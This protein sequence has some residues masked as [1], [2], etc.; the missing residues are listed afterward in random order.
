MAA[1]TENISLLK[2]A[3]AAWAQSKGTDCECWMNI[4]SDEASLASLAAGA[5]EMSFSAPRDSKSQILRYLQELTSDWDMVS[6]DMDDFIADGDRVVAVGQVAWRNKTTGKVAETP[7]VD[8]WR[9][10]QGKVV[11]LREFY[12]TARAFAAATPD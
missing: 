9:F 6:F 2:D 8:I 4:L 5:P 10:D 7:K 11:D 1:E 3:Y 12:D